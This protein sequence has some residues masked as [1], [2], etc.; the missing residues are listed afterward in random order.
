MLLI[1]D[2]L[3]RHPILETSFDD[4]EVL[5]KIW[6]LWPECTKKYGWGEINEPT[7]IT[8]RKQETTGFE[9][10]GSCKKLRAV[11]MTAGPSWRGGGG[12]LEIWSLFNFSLQFICINII[13]LFVLE[14][15]LVG[16]SYHFWPWCQLYQRFRKKDRHQREFLEFAGISTKFEKSLIFRMT[17]SQQSILET[18]QS[19]QC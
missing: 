12:L 16:L 10:K 18:R 17:V 14:F 2:S 5:R 13:V 4:T 7:I 1:L 6:K 9:G 3:D 11:I 19:K 15:P 8:K